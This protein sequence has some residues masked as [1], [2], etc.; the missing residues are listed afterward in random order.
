MC[1]PLWV[2]WDEPSGV[3]LPRKGEKKDLT[4]IGFQFTCVEM[5]NEFQC[6]STARVVADFPGTDVMKIPA[7]GVLLAKAVSAAKFVVSE[8]DRIS[9][10]SVQERMG[11]LREQKLQAFQGFLWGHP[12]YSPLE[13]GPEG[14]DRFEE[15]LDLAK[16]RHPDLEQD[17]SRRTLHRAL[18]FT[19]ADRYVRQRKPIDA[20]SVSAVVDAA[21]RHVRKKLVERRIALPC[22]MWTRAGPDA[23][24]IGPVTLMRAETFLTDPSIRWPE[25]DRHQEQLRSARDFSSKVGWIAIV[26]LP[27]TD[28]AMALARAENAADAALNVLRLLLGPD[29]TRRLRRASSWGPTARHCHFE[30]FQDGSASISATYAG[31]DELMW[32]NWPE[33]VFEEDRNTV[34]LWSGA[35][36]CGITSPRECV[37]LQQRFLDALKWYGDGVTESNDAGRLI[38]YVFSW[39]RL[40]ITGEQAALGKTV[41]ER[42]AQLCRKLPRTVDT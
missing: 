20:G 21:S 27:P 1:R 14:A 33:Y 8:I 40:V 41:I 28:K 38:K 6:F 5:E 23:I 35:A 32:S 39:E 36:I 25:A 10:L 24:D 12:D 4:C 3:T 11:R 42:A 18:V 15:I 7:R 2:V 13:C 9:S 37:P 16:M 22:R 29:R 26:E 31:D 30:V 19:F 34:R 17:C